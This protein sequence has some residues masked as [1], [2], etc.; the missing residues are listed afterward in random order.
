MP[1]ERNKADSYREKAYEYMTIQEFRDYMAAGAASMSVSLG[2][3]SIL[4][5]PKHPSAMF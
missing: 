3:Q 5:P 1:K 4:S 2:L